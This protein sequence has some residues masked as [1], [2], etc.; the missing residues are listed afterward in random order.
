[1]SDKAVITSGLVVFLAVVSFPVWQPL[2]SAGEAAAPKL[3]LP[4]DESACIEPTEYMTANHMNL[5]NDWRDAVVRE[6]RKQH[7]S[8]SGK[9]HVMSLTKT[10]LSCH[11]NR[12]TFCTRCHDYADVEPPCWDCHVEEGGN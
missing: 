10:C 8:T 9:K 7:I 6:G 3:E 1:M 5:L 2:V 12:D 4:K 11:T